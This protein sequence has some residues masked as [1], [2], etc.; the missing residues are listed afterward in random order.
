MFY[1]KE[2]LFVAV[3]FHFK[4]QSLLDLYID[5]IH[6]LLRLHFILH[7]PNIDQSLYL[8]K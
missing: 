8:F 4:V 1:K 7:T 5:F 2:L 3:I 6:G